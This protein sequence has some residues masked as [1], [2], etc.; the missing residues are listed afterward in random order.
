M[1]FARPGAGALP[2]VCELLRQA[3]EHAVPAVGDGDQILDAD[4][5]RALDVHPR[6]DRHY[7]ARLQRI[8]ARHA[9]T[10]GLVDLE[11]D[12]VAEAVAEV[13]AVA[14]LADHVAGDRVDL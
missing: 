14:G 9:Q 7:V 11:P 6:L 13:L 3:A 4:A 10:R 5:A 2:E 12:A 8:A 1:R